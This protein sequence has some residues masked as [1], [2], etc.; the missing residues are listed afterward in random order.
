MDE[1]TYTITVSNS[2]DASSPEDAVM[3]MVCWLQECAH[4]AG[5]R[6]EWES[7]VADTFRK[8]SYFIDAEKIIRSKV[9]F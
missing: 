3:Q 8:Y 9:D 1:N 4:S 2:F 5:Y 6:V 7:L